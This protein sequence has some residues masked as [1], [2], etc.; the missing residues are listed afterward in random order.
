LDKKGGKNMFFAHFQTIKNDLLKFILWFLTSIVLSLSVFWIPVLLGV[1]LHVNVYNEL[2][3]SNPFISFSVIF[4][5]NVVFSSITYKGAGSND[6]AAGI[7]N[8][9][10]VVV[11]IYLIFISAIIPAKYLM[12]KSIDQSTQYIILGL[13][14]LLGIYTYGFRDHKWEKTVEDMREKEETDVTNLIEKAECTIIDEEVS[15]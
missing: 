11:I 8:V 13:T 12:M 3:K 14:L 5:C 9:T 15:L 10:F 7:R 4:L 2:I 6:N 1:I